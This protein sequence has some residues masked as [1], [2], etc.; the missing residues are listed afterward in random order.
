MGDQPPATWTESESAKLTL[1]DV[2]KSTAEWSNVESQFAATALDCQCSITLLQ[3]VQNNELLRPFAALRQAMVSRSPGGGAGCN[4]R[5]LLL[6]FHGTEAGSAERIAVQGFNS[7]SAS[8][9]FYGKRTYFARDASC[10][11]DYSK[12]D[13]AGVAWR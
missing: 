13:A 9:H 11:V 4:E 7:S 3:L 10:S 12:P 6:L 5:M 8:V 1:V 2:V